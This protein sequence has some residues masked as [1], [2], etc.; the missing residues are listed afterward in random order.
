MTYGGA[1]RNEGGNWIQREQ[2]H[3]EAIETGLKAL[4]ERGCSRIIREI[5]SSTTVNLVL[6]G[7]P[8]F[9]NMLSKIQLAVLV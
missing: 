7:H 3:A 2:R 9:Q 4:L 1:L 8:R 5:D 6:E